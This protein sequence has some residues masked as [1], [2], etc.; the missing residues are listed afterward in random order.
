MNRTLATGGVAAGLLLISLAGAD[1]AHAAPASP[2]AA[3]VSVAGDPCA[4]RGQSEGGSNG[5]SSTGDS[6]GAGSEGQ[7]SEGQGSEEQEGGNA[8]GPE[9]TTTTPA[10]T[11]SSTP[12]KTSTTTTEPP[13]STQSLPGAR[14]KNFSRA[15]DDDDC[16]TE[17]DEDG[18]GV[19]EKADGVDN[20]GDGKVDEN[21][22]V[23]VVPEG[24]APTGDGSTEGGT[25]WW[26]GGSL[27]AALAAAGVAFRGRLARLASSSSGR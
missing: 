17:T 5:D 4:D 15:T 10:P 23:T 1:A 6:D 3:A 24:G 27:L 11:N 19:P 22:Q 25:G 18:D 13:T 20:D 9:E 26:I 8:D 16:V 7:E 12:P 14:P 21:A 2:V